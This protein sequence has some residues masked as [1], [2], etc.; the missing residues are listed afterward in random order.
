MIDD[1]KDWIYETLSR[2]PTLMLN[3][4]EAV[5]CDRQSKTLDNVSYIQSNKSS[6]TKLKF[7][8]LT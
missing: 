4:K 7:L 2:S 3:I 5:V 8:T 1:L 6:L